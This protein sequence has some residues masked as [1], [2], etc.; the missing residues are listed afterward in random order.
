MC[1]LD[2]IVEPSPLEAG[3]VLFVV[4]IGTLLLSGIVAMIVGFI[5]K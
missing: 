1:I 4:A 3:V 5:K 2:V